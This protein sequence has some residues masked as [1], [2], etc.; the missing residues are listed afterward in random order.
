MIIQ[1]TLQD[2]NLESDPYFYERQ[3]ELHQI[4]DDIKS[5]RNE[6]ISFEDFVHRTSELEKEFEL[7]YIN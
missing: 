3:K 5:G 4:R 7:K 6:L 1:K 2:K